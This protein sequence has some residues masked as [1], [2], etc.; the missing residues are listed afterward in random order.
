MIHKISTCAVALL[1]LAGL[2]LAADKT[3]SDDAIAW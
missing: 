3:V 1:L 2:C